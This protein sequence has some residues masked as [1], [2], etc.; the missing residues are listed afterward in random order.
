MSAGPGYDNWSHASRDF[1]AHEK[2][3][4]HC[5][6]VV[7]VVKRGRAIGRLDEGLARQHE[8]QQAYWSDVLRRC[9]SVIKF[10]SQRG[11][12]FRGSD[13]T[14]ASPHNGNYL[15]MLEMLS[16]Y[17]A[18][19]AQHIQQHANRGRG[20]T[21]Y[22]S[23][24]TCEELIG[25]LGESVLG[26]IIEEVKEAKYFSITVDSTPDN[27]NID[28]LTC[29][30]R[31]VAKTVP[32]ERFMSFMASTGHTGQQQATAL[33][34]F[35]QHAGL[36]IKDCRGQSYDN[37]SNMSGRYNGM[38][39]HIRRENPLAI[40]IPCT[41]HSL[42]LVGQAAVGC[43]RHAVAFFDFVQRLYVFLTTSSSRHAVLVNKLKPKG[44]LVPKSLSDTRWSAHANAM[45]ALVLGYE[46]IRACLDEIAADESV[47]GDVRCT[48]EGL[49]SQMDKLETCFFTE[50]WNFI[51]Q[52]FDA[53]SKSLQQ[54]SLDLNSAVKLLRSLSAF[55]Q[56]L[57][58][59]FES[60]TVSGGELSGTL[61]FSENTR[62]RKR[63]VRLDP[64]DY[65]RGEAAQLDPSESFRVNAF[66]SVLDVLSSEVDK[67]QEAYAEVSDRFGFLRHL[68][69]IQ[70]TEAKIVA[71]KLVKIY[72]SDL[73]S[74]AADELVQFAALAA[75]TFP[76]LDHDISPEATLYKMLIEREL[77]D[78]FPNV[79]IMLRIYL[80]LMI[81][82]CS[83]ERSFSK[84]KMIKN[85]H[86][87]TM[88]QNRLVNLT[89]LSSEW[90]ITRKIKL[91]QILTDFSAAKVHRKF[92]N[93]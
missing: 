47:K 14:V 16:E 87:S 42:N 39:A 11:L 89:L 85:D 60:F 20:H 18:F 82:N 83:G 90:D 37:A 80:T 76:D 86:R 10:L 41:A 75:D 1:I 19:I 38:Q 52:R 51:L 88:S 72:S 71:D 27:S 40:F 58:T 36:D 93:T 70:P 92:I 50:F 48:A 21:N 35:L 43:C 91:D 69:Q 31:Y 30:V 23:S 8:Q 54:S 29:C 15:G 13:E 26:K 46:D 64:L 49:S 67:R 62:T 81:S 61:T 84:L 59:R 12:A 5:N 63:N 7:T 25:L 79:E 3:A 78:A 57:R 22:L 9:V 74:R 44:L 33:L 66:I 65:G 56:T 53:T 24:T 4:H 32:V 45:K 68:A 6:N 77:R 17:D 55:I 73:D 28:Q 2:S 34:E